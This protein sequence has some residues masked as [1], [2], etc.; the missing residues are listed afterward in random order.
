MPAEN[1]TLTAVWKVKVDIPSTVA[2]LVYNGSLQT[3][4]LGGMGYTLT[5][6]TGTN[7]G[8]YSVTTVLSAGYIWSDG[9]TEDKT[10][11]WNIAKKEITVT[12]DALSKVYGGADPVFTY[13]LSE[14]VSVMGDLGR[15]AGEDV[16]SYAI[17]LGSL[18]PESGNYK[19]ALPE[20]DVMFTIISGHIFLVLDFDSAAYTGNPILP[21]VTVKDDNDRILGPPSYGVFYYNNVDVGEALVEVIGIGN[22]DGAYGSAVLTITP[23]VG[24]LVITFEPV[25]EGS[26]TEPPVIVRDDLGATLIRDVDYSVS[27]ENNTGTG[28]A[29]VIVTGMG[30]YLGTTGTSHFEVTAYTLPNDLG[31]VVIKDRATGKV[32]G[33]KDIVYQ[34]Q[35][36]IVTPSSKIEGDY[37]IYD[38]QGNSIGSD[39]DYTVSG[40]VYGPFTV[41]GIPI[42]DPE[43]VGEWGTTLGISLII[44]LI[45]LRYVRY[46]MRSGP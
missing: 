7:A 27:Y 20:P 40:P 32:L 24:N 4:V 43:N 22:Y 1:M 35:K 34:G 11:D 41:E 44:L 9:T 39:G 5:G 18:I 3:G 46:R 30:N 15:E 25:Y 42:P 26:P 37:V 36:L 28:T 29:T 17:N 31:H 6:N 23:Y 13:T 2:G 19:L 14:S 33:P 38:W 10:I 16:G 45:L 21:A 8:D 12:P